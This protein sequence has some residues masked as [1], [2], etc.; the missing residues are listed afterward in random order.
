M[1]QSTDGPE[2]EATNSPRY[3]LYLGRCRSEGKIPCR[4]PAALKVAPPPVLAPQK[5]LTR[6]NSRTNRRYQWGLGGVRGSWTEI[7]V[8]SVNVHPPQISLHK[9]RQHRST[10]HAEGRQA[11]LDTCAAV[12]SSVQSRA[13]ESGK[14][15]RLSPCTR[16]WLQRRFF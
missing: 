3:L 9:H 12:P 10:G 8:G 14:A 1:S 13:R 7:R 5:L 15:L 11:V 2:N 6:Q 4:E 16:S